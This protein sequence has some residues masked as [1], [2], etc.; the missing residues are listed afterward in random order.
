MSSKSFKLCSKCK[1]E[2]LKFEFSFDR[3]ASD[4]LSWW[5]KECVK[6]C[7]N[8]RK[9]LKRN[10]KLEYE[11]GMLPGQYEMILKSQNGVCAICHKI[12]LT[13]KNLAVD[14]C[15][16]TNKIRGLLCHKC[17]VSL[18]G[19]YDNLELL[20]AAIKYLEKYK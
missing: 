15:H 20:R 12:C 19:F 5:C 4:G 3:K 14:H 11:Y 13:N 18:G 8:K 2:K 16:K 6:K 7:A 10:R 9:Y 1:I 17:N